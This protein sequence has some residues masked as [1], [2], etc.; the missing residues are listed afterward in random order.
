MV[1][2]GEKDKSPFCSN[3]MV[4]NRLSRFGN[5]SFFRQINAEFRDGPF[6]QHGSGPLSES[7][8]VPH[9]GAEGRA[10]SS[11]PTF[12]TMRIDAFSPLSFSVYIQISRKSLK[13]PGGCLVL[14]IS[15]FTTAFRS[16]ALEDPSGGASAHHS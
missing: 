3:A 8:V 2:D 13:A 9:I 16:G 4:S 14:H 1:V 5:A 12:N 6:R 10:V 7:F 15:L 11:A